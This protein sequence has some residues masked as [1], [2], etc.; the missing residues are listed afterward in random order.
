LQL[1]SARLLFMRLPIVFVLFLLAN[2]ALAK[3]A[4]QDEPV[5]FSWALPEDISGTPFESVADRLRKVPV[6]RAEFVQNKWFPGSEKPVKATGN[7]LLASEDGLYWRTVTPLPMTL[8]VTDDFIAI[9]D[10]QGKLRRLGSAMAQLRGYADVILAMFSAEVGEIR[11]FFEVYFGYA[12]KK[13]VIGLK[14]KEKRLQKYM[15]YA[16]LTGDSHV[17]GIE[18]VGPNGDRT[19]FAFSDVQLEPPELTEAEA[20]IFVDK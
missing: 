2:L 17:E 20:A 10:H 14:P 12:N 9:R 8:V 11:E 3:S 16:T 18:F 19:E 1:P 15:Q 5:V 6:M 7:F 4:G 13:W